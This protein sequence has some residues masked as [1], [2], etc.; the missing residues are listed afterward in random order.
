MLCLKV[1]ANDDA[2]FDCSEIINSL[3]HIGYNSVR[4][5]KKNHFCNMQQRVIELMQQRVNKMK[6]FKFV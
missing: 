2:A 1:I 4:M 6:I 5:T 3:L